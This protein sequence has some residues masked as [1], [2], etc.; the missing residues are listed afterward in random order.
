MSGIVALIARLHSV[1][2]DDCVHMDGTPDV[3]LLNI[4][5]G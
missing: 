2:S 5:T 4:K 3:Y 1:D